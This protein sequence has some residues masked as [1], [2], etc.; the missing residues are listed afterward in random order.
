MPAP[1]LKRALDAQADFK[2]AM[3]G[4]GNLDEMRRL[5]AAVI[6]TWSGPLPD[7]VQ[8]EEIDAGGV[9]AVRLTPPGAKRGR[10]LMYLHGGGLILGSPAAVATPVAHAA[11]VGHAG[12]VLPRYRLAPEHPYPAMVEDA[13]RAYLWL[14]E[15]GTPPEGIVIAGESAGGGLVCAVILALADRGHPLPAAAVLI[16]P[17]VDFELKGDSW[18]TNAGRE[19]FV[20]RELV[21]ET[22]RVFLPDG[23]AVEESPLNRDLAG[24]PPLLIQVGDHEVIRDDAI[25]L[26]QKAAAAGVDV[27]LEVVPEMVHLWH[28]FSY[29]PEAEQSLRQIGAFLEERMDAAER[30]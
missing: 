13:V 25:A 11:R 23:D 28:T 22:I 29:L 19:G 26:A 3:A 6:P 17:L 9:P 30:S 5:D 16:S 18:R 10:V 8:R 15:D 4:V 27:T 21:L 12:A 20:S 1:E 14:I 2:A 7:D 24:F